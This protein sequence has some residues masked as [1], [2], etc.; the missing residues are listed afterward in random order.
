[1]K[2]RLKFLEESYLFQEATYFIIPIWGG[3][4]SELEILPGAQVTG[5]NFIRNH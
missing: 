2:Q 3:G 4:L 1:M 5:G